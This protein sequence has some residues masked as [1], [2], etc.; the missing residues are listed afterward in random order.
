MSKSNQNVVSCHTGILP[1][2][3]PVSPTL[4]AAGPVSKPATYEPVSMRVVRM[5][6]ERVL[7]ASDPGWSLSGQAPDI[8]GVNDVGSY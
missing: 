2:V 5:A 8:G 1:A 6:P 4:P 3:G 7:C